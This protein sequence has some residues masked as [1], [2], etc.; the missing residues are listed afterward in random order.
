MKKFRGP[1]EKLKKISRTHL[2]IAGLFG[3]LLLVIALPVD[4]N[5]RDGNEQETEPG[6]QPS[7]ENRQERTLYSQQETEL[8]YQKQLEQQ[9]T[10]ILS[11]MEGVGHVS[12]MITLKDSGETQVEKDVS[13][14]EEKSAESDGE[15]SSRE[16]S[17]V[18][19]SEA[20]VYDQTDSS[21]Q[22]PFVKKITLPQVEGVLVVAEGAGNATVVKNISDAIVA[23]FQVEAHRIKVVGMQSDK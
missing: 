16:S 13:R 12:V 4:Q 19:L 1:L 23:L 8:T 2:L 11:E 3:I 7:E 5:K 14:T 18:N 10:E 9:L 21:V 22:T 17:G 6:E 20:T 15:G